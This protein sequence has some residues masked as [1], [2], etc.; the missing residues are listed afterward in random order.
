MVGRTRRGRQKQKQLGNHQ[1]SWIW[2]RNAVMETL[3]DGKWPVLELVLSENLDED[4]ITYCQRRAVELE[5]THSVQPAG[6]LTALCR[7]AE[8]QGL[9]ARM[10]S[11]PYSSEE[12]VFASLTEQALIVVLD[13]IQDPY[14]FGAM[15]RTFAAFGVDAVF[16]GDRD[17]VGIN[18]LVA[19]ASAGAVSMI[20]IVRVPDL[21]RLMKKLK[22]AG[23]LCFVASEK[24]EL[25]YAK[26]DYC[27]ATAFVIGNEGRGVSHEVAELCDDKISIPL[28]R[29]IDSLNAAV[30]AGILVSEVNRQRHQ[31][32]TES[33][34][35][36]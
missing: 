27:K 5:I 2:G 10:A 14:N 30:A 34:P 33:C 26:C 35:L 18:S 3:R 4:L 25:D 8:H 36:N 28:S 16:I 15:I 20:P 29:S 31:Q 23:V 11:F 17:Q 12:S 13:S 6:R 21:K 24:S 22:Q 7:S 9:L 32:K 1:R 19:R